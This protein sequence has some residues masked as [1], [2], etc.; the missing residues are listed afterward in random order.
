MARALHTTVGMTSR[1]GFLA[2]LFGGAAVSSLVI[3]SSGC[4]ADDPATVGA[5]G[6]IEGLP[7]T[8]GLWYANAWPAYAPAIRQSPAVAPDWSTAKG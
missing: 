2:Q 1:R 4:V 3:A 5:D 8:P 7:R 6:A